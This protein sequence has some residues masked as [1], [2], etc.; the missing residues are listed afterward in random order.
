MHEKD[1][2][3]HLRENLLEHASKMVSF[4]YYACAGEK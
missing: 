1:G 3:I 4:H 2:Q